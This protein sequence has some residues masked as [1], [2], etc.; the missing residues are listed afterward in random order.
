MAQ[1]LQVACR[2]TNVTDGSVVGESSRTKTTT[3]DAAWEQKGSVGTTEEEWTIGVEV[4]NAGYCV[5]RNFDTANYLEVGFS[6]GSYPI[7]ILAG[8]TDKYSLSPTQASLFLKAN[9]AAVKA[10]VRVFEA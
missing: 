1:T 10:Q 4:G 7:R 5:I 9:T 8:D 3:G 6:T 2:I